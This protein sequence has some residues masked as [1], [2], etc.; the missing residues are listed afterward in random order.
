MVRPSQLFLSLFR[1]VCNL[2]KTQ[3]EEECYP[4]RSF[5]TARASL[6]SFLY[7][8]HRL[9]PFPQPCFHYVVFHLLQFNLIVDVSVVE[10]E[11]GKGGGQTRPDVGLF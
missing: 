3:W 1:I 4:C 7:P 11:G 2:I 10:M 8:I 9:Q 6:L 5:P